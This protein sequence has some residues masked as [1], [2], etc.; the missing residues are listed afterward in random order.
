MDNRK[1][2]LFALVAMVLWGLSF[3]INRI[4]LQYITPVELAFFKYGTF[5]FIMLIAAPFTK[6]RLPRL[7]DVPTFALAG[8]VGICLYNI[9]LNQGL[10]TTTA[11]TTS[12]IMASSP[13][14]M[15]LLTRIFLK[16]KLETK[17]WIPILFQFSGVVIISVFDGVLKLNIGVVW[18]IIAMLFS[19]MYSLIQRMLQQYRPVE[20]MTYGTFFGGLFIFIAA[21]SSLQVVVT[22]PPNIVVGL[23]AFGVFVIALSNLLW[24]FALRMSTSMNAIGNFLFLPPVFAAFFGAIILKEIPSIATAIGGTIII[25]GSIYFNRLKMQLAKTKVEAEKNNI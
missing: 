16:E 25:L 8:L 6:I 14:V 4:F 5:G 7:K 1:P 10:T 20:V 22:L 21:P 23:F 9:S 3:S 2:I 19:T 11:A 15:V 12:M 18:V 24:G 13:I 17:L